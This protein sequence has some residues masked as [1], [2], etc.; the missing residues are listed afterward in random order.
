M[1]VVK[2]DVDAQALHP[3]FRAEEDA[4]TRDNAAGAVGRVIATL[5]A[6]TPLEQAPAPT[7]C[8][9]KLALT[10]ALAFRRTAGV[11]SIAMD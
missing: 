3:L 9:A 5:G 2:G 11:L 10:F 4:G 7:P 6:Q 1:L 8:L